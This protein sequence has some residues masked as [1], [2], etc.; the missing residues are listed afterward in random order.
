MPK[1]GTAKT[2]LILE[3]EYLYL[4]LAVVQ[5]ERI[6]FEVISARTVDEALNLLTE[7]QTYNITPTTVD[8]VWIDHFLP[9][10]NGQELVTALRSDQRWKD[11]PMFLV[12]N[13]VETDIVNWYLR[14]GIVQV[15]TKVTTPVEKVVASIDLYLQQH[16]NAQ[17]PAPVS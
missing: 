8:A 10:K 1:P 4:E 5:C 7:L 15:F 11:V 6:G 12:T 2:L 9:E 13:A 17:A 16:P 14:N 3:D